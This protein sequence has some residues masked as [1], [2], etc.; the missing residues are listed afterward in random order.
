MIIEYEYWLF[1]FVKW[2]NCCLFSSVVMYI[3][4]LILLVLCIFVWLFLYWLLWCMLVGDE[5]V[6][7]RFG[8]NVRW[9]MVLM[10]WRCVVVFE[11]FDGCMWVEFFVY[12]VYVVFLFLI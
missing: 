2:I 4:L 8:V 6:E 11:I 12:T 3:S 7:Y 9:L 1:W 10:W 5:W